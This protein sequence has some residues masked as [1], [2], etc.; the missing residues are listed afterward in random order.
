MG[1]KSCEV[2]Q[3]AKRGYWREADARVLIEAW[4]SSGEPLTRFARRH[5]V[6]RRRLARWLSRLERAGS[7]QLNFVP[8][9]VVAPESALGNGVG[10][11]IEI[12]LARGVRVRVPGGFAPEDL[13]SVL[14][15]LAESTPC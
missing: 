12:Q 15:V 13:R 8:V 1:R 2:R 7:R 10:A 5:G 4:R 14:S 9:R 11:A 3:T 6:R